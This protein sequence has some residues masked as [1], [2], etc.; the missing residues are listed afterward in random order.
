MS[1]QDHLESDDYDLDHDQDV[2]LLSRF[3]LPSF[4]APSKKMDDDDLDTLLTEHQVSL[5]SII[6]SS[7]CECNHDR[8][9]LTCDFLLPLAEGALRVH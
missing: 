6:S 2:L 9:H 4:F 8:N 3:L 1:D 7:H 5:P